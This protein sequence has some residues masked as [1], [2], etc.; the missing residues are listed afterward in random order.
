MQAKTVGLITG[1]FFI[2]RFNIKKELQTASLELG[3]VHLGLIFISLGQTVIADEPIDCNQ[4]P[5]GDEYGF[6]AKPY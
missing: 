4:C 2:V 5:N 1:G 3:N 6:D